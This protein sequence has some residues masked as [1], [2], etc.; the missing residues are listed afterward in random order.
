MMNDLAT[1]YDQHAMV[2]NEI[3][4]RLIEH[5]NEVQIN[6]R[7]ILNLGAKTGYTTKLLA[8]KYSRAE[9]ISLDISEHF[10][11]KIK[12]TLFKSTNKVAAN[13]EHLPFQADVFD[14]IFSNL[15]L[16]RFDYKKVF[17]EIL[18]ILKINGLF[19]FSTFGM[20]IDMHDL[21]DLLMQL[22]FSDPVLETEHID[23]IYKN[24]DIFIEDMRKTGYEN[25][26]QENLN[27]SD[28][29]FK[30]T[31]EII[32]GHAWK[33]TKT[34]KSDEVVIPVSKIRRT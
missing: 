2:Q 3:A 5:L 1:T 32:Y 6:P 12:N 21:G 19:L 8:K 25:L 13:T 23:F 30:K 27:S 28:H 17:S 4:E 7:I 33:K 18:S 31:F 20:N 10:L 14:L 11:Q 29:E 16:H 26:L 9:I 22:G 15:S 24:S 34:E